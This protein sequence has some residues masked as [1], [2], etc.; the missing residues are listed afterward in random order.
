MAQ[1]QLP[2][3]YVQ[4]ATLEAP[5]PSSGKGAPGSTAAADD[6]REGSGG[7]S[8]GVPLEQVGSAVTVVTGAQLQAQQI[9]HAADALRSLPGVAVSRTG[10]L[11]GVTQVRIRGAEGNHTLV[12]IDGI[13]A[14][15]NALGEFDFASLLAEDIER[16]EIIRGPQSGLYGSKAV[17][18]VINIVT[19]TGKGPLTASL[20]TEGGSLGTYDVSGRVSGGNDRAWFYASAQRRGAQFFNWSETGSEDDPWRSTTLTLK[21]GVTLL[22]GV[23]LDFN[24]R[25]SRNFTNTDDAPFFG[26]QVP[27][28]SFGT[29][30][31]NVFLGGVKLK[32]DSLNGALSQVVSFDRN[33]TEVKTQSEL[34]GPSDN[35]NARD[36]L[37][38]LATYRFDTPTFLAA[39][40]TVS[41]QVDTQ[42]ERFTPS[43]DGLERAR[44]QVGVVGEYRGEF[45]KRLYVTGN[46][47]HDD[48]DTFQDFTT[49]RTAAS[50]DLPE[51]K[52]RPHASVGT[53]VALP[54][55]FEQFGFF[56]GSP[57]FKGNPSLQPE[58][59][60]GWDAG[61]EFALIKDRAFLDVTYFHANL[62]NEIVGFGTSIANLNGESER[63]GIEVAL[64]AQLTPSL[65]FGASYTYL[66]AVGADLNLDPTGTIAFPEV[67]RPRHAGRADLTYV[68][69]D[70]RG[71]VNLAAIYNG[72][73]QDNA[74]F[75]APDFTFTTSRVTLDD[76]WLVNLAASY[77]LQK[78][79]ELF[80]RVENALDAQYQEVF[81]FNTPGITTF[82]G[83]R[84]TFGGPDGVAIGAAE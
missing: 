75:V 9:R 50:L 36:K 18:G 66:D 64:R 38:Y 31:T 53:G 1:T 25:D 8:E 26:L 48:N 52:I 15:D 78:G 30:D 63:S 5:R 12:L 49:W 10:S 83:V 11:A 43:S 73:M 24:L 23:T 77:R 16:I 40:H 82:A 17:G 72:R 81:G 57:P 80:G 29:S 44:S 39:K 84:F 13:D 69:A 2:G 60:L 45:F 62:T 20:R 46:V 47:R 51:L 34:F 4:G 71:S 67:R 65:R 54:G 42:T 32:W 59:S 28:D 55:M 35:D 76:Y 3:I 33:L 41:G 61:V 79:V 6:A 58:E 21:G 22:E 68:F 74:G 7:D 70:G 27:F 56:L 19:K 14:G 37:A